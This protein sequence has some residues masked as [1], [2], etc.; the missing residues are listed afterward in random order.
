MTKSQMTKSNVRNQESY[1]WVLGIQ[2]INEKMSVQVWVFFFLISDFSL[3]SITIFIIHL[4]FQVSSS[5]VSF[6]FK[7]SFKFH[8][9]VLS[10]IVK[11]VGIYTGAA[12]SGTIYVS[13]LKHHFH[14]FE[15]LKLCL[16]ILRKQENYIIIMCETKC[17]F[18]H[19]F[20]NLYFNK[21]SFQPPS[22]FDHN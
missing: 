14:C 13:F 2:K 17:S 15:K 7:E 11:L 22:G 19:H 4:I 16:N 18:F 10:I 5:I 21:I 8:C 1:M 9:G 6:Y 20:T 3:S 12:G